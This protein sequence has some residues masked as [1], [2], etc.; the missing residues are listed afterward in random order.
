MTV[1]TNLSFR[2]NGSKAGV[3]WA[4]F[5]T[6]SVRKE[7]SIRISEEDQRGDAIQEVADAGADAARA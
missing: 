7:V 5:L 3:K 4:C 2:L 6:F 1:P